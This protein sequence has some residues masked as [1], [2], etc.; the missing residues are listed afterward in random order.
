[1]HY[2]NRW[3][4]RKQMYEWLQTNVG[5]FMNGQIITGYNIIEDGKYLR[6]TSGKAMNLALIPEGLQSQ[7][8]KKNQ[9]NVL[10][11]V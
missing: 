6:F 5:S 7:V 9:L 1:M 11:S 3:Y 4:G 8:R 10:L 2:P